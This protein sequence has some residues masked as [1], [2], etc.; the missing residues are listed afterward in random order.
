MSIGVIIVFAI[1]GALWL[2]GTYAAL[3]FL[4]TTDPPRD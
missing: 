1:G 3:G 4:V 2:Y